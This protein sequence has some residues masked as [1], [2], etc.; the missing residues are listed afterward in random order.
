M[1]HDIGQAWRF[2]P[3]SCLFSSA[4]P[5][6]RISIPAA[7]LTLNTSRWQTRSSRHARGGGPV[8][9]GT[10]GGTTLACARYAGAA[11]AGVG[12]VW[13]W[14]SRLVSGP[15]GWLP[16]LRKATF[17]FA[18]LALLR[19]GSQPRKF[20]SKVNNKVNGNGKSDTKVNYK[21]KNRAAPS[22]CLRLPAPD[23][24]LTWQRMRHQRRRDLWLPYVLPALRAL[25]TP[26]SRKSQIPANRIYRY[27]VTL[28][29]R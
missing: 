28:T 11:G 9:D 3:V 29:R 10:T 25:F 6:Y 16:A 4:R 12:W 18:P 27:Q 19:A 8:D 24:N 1:G 17:R 2:E 22:T 21:S 26:A 7:G 13:G 23:S 15:R 14:V 5:F 20:N